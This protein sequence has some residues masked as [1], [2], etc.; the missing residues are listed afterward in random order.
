M[1]TIN[2]NIKKAIK[3]VI[4]LIREDITSVED[5]YKFSRLYNQNKFK[6]S[7]AY[8]VKLQEHGINIVKCIK[9][10]LGLTEIK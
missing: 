1:T 9:G 7:E 6:N 5:L 8:K 4:K 10:K 2:I 3:N